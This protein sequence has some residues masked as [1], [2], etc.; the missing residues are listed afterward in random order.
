MVNQ[1]Q[2][3]AL[4]R[5]PRFINSGVIGDSNIADS[6]T[7][8]GVAAPSSIANTLTVNNTSYSSLKRISLS[9]IRGELLIMI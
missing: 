8:V 4:N 2:G 3:Q 7:A 1:L 9:I 5:I 6:N